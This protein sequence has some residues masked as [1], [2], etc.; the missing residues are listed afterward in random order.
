MCTNVVTSPLEPVWSASTQNDTVVHP[1]TGAMPT[2]DAV[3]AWAS[4]EIRRSTGACSVRVGLQYSA[5]GETWDTA[6]G[7]GPAAAT[8]EGE[9]QDTTF[10]WVDL[11]ALGSRKRF[12]RFV[13][14]CVNTAGDSVEY[15]DA[16][17]R[18]DLTGSD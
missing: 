9:H 11:T 13:L 5:D 3:K 17:F 10:A 2:Q 12:V 4:F 18:I 8:S 15:C 14:L 1:R 7:F 6:V 16:G